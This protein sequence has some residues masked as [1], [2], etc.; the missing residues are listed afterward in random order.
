MKVNWYELVRSLLGL[1]FSVQ[2]VP[3]LWNVS[4]VQFAIT[5]FFALV[6]YMK[7]TQGSLLGLKMF[8]FF[9]AEVWWSAFRLNPWAQ[10]ATL[11]FFT[12]N[13]ASGYHPDLFTYSFLICPWK[14]QYTKS[15]FSFRFPI[16]QNKNITIPLS[17]VLSQCTG[18]FLHSPKC[19]F[20]DQDSFVSGL[21]GKFS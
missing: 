5:P 20:W 4:K 2:D 14:A 3:T 6:I 9:W 18:C 13:P 19:R 10:L 11:P 15:S 21:F 16:Y 7:W 12:F 17:D 1:K 8:F